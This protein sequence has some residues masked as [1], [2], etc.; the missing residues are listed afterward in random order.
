[1]SESDHKTIICGTHGNVDY[2][3]LCCHLKKMIVEGDPKNVKYFFAD[4]EKTEE[5]TDKECIWCED[6]DKL[7]RSEGY[8]SERATEYADPGILCEF[9]I[10]KFKS[11][12]KQGNL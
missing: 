3:L 11:N 1:M 2:G 4:A 7:L 12:N 9:C 5:V 6:C 8:W 10:Y